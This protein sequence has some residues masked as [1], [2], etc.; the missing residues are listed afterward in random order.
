MTG[1]IP[2]LNRQH[3]ETT[4]SST[5]EK[6]K[7]RGKLR[8]NSS[9]EDQR[10]PLE[11]ILDFHEQKDIFFGQRER[12]TT[13][14]DSGTEENEQ[15]CEQT[16]SSTENV[17]EDQPSQFVA[18]FNADE[19]YSEDEND[20]TS[21]IL[22]IQNDRKLSNISVLLSHDDISKTNNSVSLQHS[23]FLV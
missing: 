15:Q 4:S 10:E 11:V 23:F 9:A 16:C 17:D 18:T 13:D 1:S 12:R 6:A 22:S 7:Q 8:R 14:Y 5:M 19:G 3:S 20:E 21:K 2:T